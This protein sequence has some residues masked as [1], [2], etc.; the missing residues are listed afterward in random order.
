MKRRA[1]EFGA[2][3]IGW[4]AAWGALGAALSIVAGIVDPATIDPGEGPVD[5]ARK[6]GS[7]GGGTGIVFGLFLSIAERGKPIAEVSLLRALLSGIVAGAVLP[8]LL[9]CVENSV[10]ANTCPLAAL[11]AV[12]SVTLARFAKRFARALA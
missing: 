7:V 2:L 5:L 1:I 11:S 4:M 12:L 8:L 6:L 3:G 10:I 9:P